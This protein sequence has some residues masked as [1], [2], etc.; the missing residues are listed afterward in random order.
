MNRQH[1]TALIMYLQKA[2]AVVPTTGAEWDSVRGAL[3][4]I[5]QLAN[6]Q[7]T[8]TSAPVATVA[9]PAN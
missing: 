2:H 3:D 1:A 6:G 7:I 5:A 8:L 9:E 4:V